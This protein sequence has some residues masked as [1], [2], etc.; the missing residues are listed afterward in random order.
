MWKAELA[1]VNMSPLPLMQTYWHIPVLVGFVHFWETLD[2]FYNKIIK[3]FTWVG[4]GKFIF[5]PKA[6]ERGNFSTICK[7]KKRKDSN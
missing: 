6:L 1:S 3:G 5:P 7:L 4:K 2:T